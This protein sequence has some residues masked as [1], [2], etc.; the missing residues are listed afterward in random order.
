[1]PETQANAATTRSYLTIAGR[2]FGWLEYASGACLLVLLGVLST[3]LWEMTAHEWFRTGNEAYT[4]APLMPFIAL[5]FIWDQRQ[6]LARLPVRFSWAG[7]A[8]LFLGVLIFVAGKIGADRFTG[9]VAIATLLVGLVWAHFGNAITRRLVFPL[10]LFYLM[11]PIPSIIYRN[12]SFNLQI[13]S[14]K[15]SVS[16]M[17]L[18]AL[19]VHREGNV[20]DL[21]YT[22][23]EVAEA[24]SGITSL[25]SLITVAYI[26]AYVAR[27]NFWARTILVASAIPIAVLTNAFRIGGTGML[28]HYWSIKAAEGFFHSFAGWFVFIVAFAILLA[29][30]WLMG[31]LWS[32]RHR[33]GHQ[34]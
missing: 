16:F 26:F 8:Y 29:E 12:L 31:L 11:I 21:Y 18:F 6:E 4:H 32:F 34:A 28:A 20:I 3:P 19:P 14:S 22:Q 23:L 24:C 33:A 10:S 5:Y 25:V 7:F 27:R 2:G 30:N 1:M 15:L 13:L 9:Q 17:Q